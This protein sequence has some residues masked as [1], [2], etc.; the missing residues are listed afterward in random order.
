MH[1]QITPG[2]CKC[3]EII[4]AEHSPGFGSR[5]PW[6]KKKKSEKEEQG[7]QRVSFHAF[8]LSLMLPSL[9]QR[10][11]WLPLG[12]AAGC[13]Q[14]DGAAR[15]LRGFTSGGGPASC[16]LGISGSAEASC[17]LWEYASIGIH[18]I[19]SQ[20]LHPVTPGNS[21]TCCL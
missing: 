17:W 1:L 15:T 16:V 13:A 11:S 14:E 4:K 10:G 21:N 5:D 9:P 18:A 3:L 12:L 20:L 19:W 7:I 8:P 2:R 6:W